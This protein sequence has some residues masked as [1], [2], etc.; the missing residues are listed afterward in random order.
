[1]STI[2]EDYCLQTCDM[3]NDVGLLLQE[4]GLGIL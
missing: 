2:G 1:M 3:I 4:G